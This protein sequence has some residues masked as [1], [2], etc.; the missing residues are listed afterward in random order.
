MTRVAETKHFLGEYLEHFR[1]HVIQ[2]KDKECFDCNVYVAGG[3][4]ISL[5][6]GEKPKD[7]DIYVRDADY[8]AQLVTSIIRHYRRSNAIVLGGKSVPVAL[9][10]SK[11]DYVP[12]TQSVSIGIEGYPQVSVGATNSKDSGLFLS[13]NAVS[14]KAKVTGLPVEAQLITRFVGKPLDVVRCFDFDH[15]RHI[16]TG[17]G[18]LLLSSEGLK[19][20]STRDLRYSGSY[21]PLTSIIRTK[22]F[23]KRGW[24]CSAGEYLKMTIQAAALD[25]TSKAV[26]YDQLEG[27]DVALFEQLIAAIEATFPGAETPVEPAFVFKQIDKIFA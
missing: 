21:F 6:G 19:S 8:A 11:V 13:K 26:L 16:Y 23:I 3:S 5:L 24:N 18:E 4:I 20:Q 14:I 9:Q 25:W 17:T 15:T 2:E 12:N 27:V 1:T 22:K 10:V 7:V